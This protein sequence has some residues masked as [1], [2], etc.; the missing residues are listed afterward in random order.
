MMGYFL[1]GKSVSIL[2]KQMLVSVLLAAENE[3]YLVVS[4][5][6]TTFQFRVLAERSVL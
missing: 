5:R 3:W 4:R 6:G 1:T 2:A